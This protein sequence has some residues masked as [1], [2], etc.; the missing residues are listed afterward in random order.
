L[1]TESSSFAERTSLRIQRE[2]EK[3]EEE[4]YMYTLYPSLYGVDINIL[5]CGLYG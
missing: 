3:F 5:Q 1:A 4:Y 2:D